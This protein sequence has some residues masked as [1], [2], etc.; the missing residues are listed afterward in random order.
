MVY[1]K[2]QHISRRLLVEGNQNVETLCNI[3]KDILEIFPKLS[4]LTNLN[5]NNLK[6]KDNNNWIKLEMN[7]PLE[8]QI[9]QKD[10]IYFDLKFTDVWVDVIMTLKDEEDKT[11]TNKFNFELK[12]NVESDRQE[13]EKNLIYSGIGIWEPLKEP[14]DYYLFTG[15]EIK[16]EKDLIKEGAIKMAQQ[17]E[18][19]RKNLIKF[20]NKNNNN[21]QEFNNN[22]YKN[23][24]NDKFK[25]SF[26]EKISCTLKFINFTNYIY[27]YVTKE[28]KNILK[29]NSYNDEYFNYKQEEEM[30]SIKSFFNNKF[31]NLY[32]SKSKNIDENVNEKKIKNKI[33]FKVS[34]EY[35]KEK[36]EASNNYNIYYNSTNYSPEVLPIRNMGSYMSIKSFGKINIE[37]KDFIQDSANY[38]FQEKKYRNS[39]NSFNSSNSDKISEKEQIDF[40]KEENFIEEIKY[41]M[42]EIDF[43]DIFDNIHPY[44]LCS[45]FKDCYDGRTRNLKILEGVLLKNTKLDFKEDVIKNTNTIK[46]SAFKDEDDN[47]Y[48]NQLIKKHVIIIVI[49]ILVIILIKIIF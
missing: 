1:I 19:S 26:N 18:N 9:K 34:Q 33:L 36:E 10:T 24:S 3:I 47:Y 27:K 6:K 22:L 12:M 17:L 15:I 14:N 48:Q 45:N 44:I 49:I 5:V 42:Y 20:N 43:D 13:I 38:S 30:K 29:D 37:M 32:L 7:I 31:N 40:E 21:E 4:G 28:M 35:F 39:L 8:K 25:F 16:S 41:I 23:Q 46:T 2:N 11:K